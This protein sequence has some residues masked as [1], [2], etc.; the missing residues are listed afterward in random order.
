MALGVQMARPSPALLAELP[1]VMKACRAALAIANE[2]KAKK[3]QETREETAQK[4]KRKRE[5]NKAAAL[6]EQASVTA[7]RKG[8]AALSGKTLIV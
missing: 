5:A 1:R 6:A 2:A 3:R 4:Q 8:L 7:R